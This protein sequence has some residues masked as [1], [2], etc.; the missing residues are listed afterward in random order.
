M[1]LHQI[2]E[3]L[4]RQSARY[5]RITKKKPPKL[6]QQ[7]IMIKK[8]PPEPGVPDYITKDELWQLHIA[9]SESTQATRIALDELYAKY[10]LSK[11]EYR[12]VVRDGVIIKLK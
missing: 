1:N 11:M 7:T 9:R 12:I 6:L 8:S 3:T 10:G 2:V 4:Y 5:A